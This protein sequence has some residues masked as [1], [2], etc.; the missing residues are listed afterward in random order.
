MIWPL[1]NHNRIKPA[2]E[3][4]LITIAAAANWRSDRWVSVIFARPSVLR[5]LVRYDLIVWNKTERRARLTESGL[6]VATIASE[7]EEVRQ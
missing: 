2:D 1:S 4:L 6:G 3:A 5:A 7:K